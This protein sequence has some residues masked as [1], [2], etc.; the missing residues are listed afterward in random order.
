[1]ATFNGE[2]WLDEQIDTLATQED[3]EVS[4]VVSD[5]QS[6]DGTLDL[7]ASR[8]DT[9]CVH[10]MPPA[11]RRHGNANRNF[12]RLIDEAPL[13]AAAFV[14]FA[15]QDDVWLRDKLARAVGCLS[16]LAAQAYS[17]DVIAFWPDGR[18]HLVRKSRPQR[19]F[20]HL[21]ESPGPGCTFVFTREAFLELRQ[22]VAASRTELENLKVHDW[23]IY[24]FGR[25]RGWRW[26]IDDVATMRYRQHGQNEIG[27][28]HGSAAIRHR[29][30]NIASGQYRNDVLRLA[31]A[32]GNQSEPIR[33]LE[34]LGWLDR[35]RL[36]ILA[37]ECRRNPREAAVL[38]LAFLL[39]RRDPP[40][41]SSRG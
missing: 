40:E 1:M 15:D 12:L 2:R 4:L 37:R 3:V 29:V 14:A 5:D 41:H 25:E 19:A 39:T 20:D 30:R 27:A 38:A 10:V 32:I 8:R 33:L 11:G 13:G 18:E 26:H 28:N 22:W 16:T 21:F 34:R 36:M 9:L 35:L 24:A 7:I 17:S 6:S 31:R 23:S